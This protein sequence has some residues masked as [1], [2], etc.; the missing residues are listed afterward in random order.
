MAGLK[1]GIHE[2]YEEIQVPIALNRVK[3]LE[4]GKA[5]P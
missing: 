2:G 3:I 1:R 5:A 4:K